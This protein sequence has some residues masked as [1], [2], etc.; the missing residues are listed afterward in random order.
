MACA[1]STELSTPVAETG[2][3]PARAYELDPSVAVRHEPFGALVYHYGTRRL[4][5]L[6]SH[7]LVAVVEALAGHGSALGAMEA[8]GVVEA[9]RPALTKA[10][11]S[12]YESE[13]IRA[14]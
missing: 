5:F 10:L 8:A 2:F 4:N 3:D 12:L 1:G 6:R 9:R 11:S 7:E 14:R 13:V